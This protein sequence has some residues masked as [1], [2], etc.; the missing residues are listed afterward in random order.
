MFTPFLELKLVQA[1][2]ALGIASEGVVKAY[3]HLHK[4][5]PAKLPCLL[6]L[7]NPSTY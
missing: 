3:F 1:L 5:A 6:E 7:K 2:Q 4:L